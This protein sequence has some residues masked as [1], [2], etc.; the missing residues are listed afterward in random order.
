MRKGKPP[1]VKG[2]PKPSLEELRHELQAEQAAREGS[3]LPTVLT[4]QYEKARQY[5]QD[6][7]IV[8][9]AIE[10]QIGQVAIKYLD[11]REGIALDPTVPP[12]QPS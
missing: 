10:P 2:R 7:E 12:P 8:G 3:Q 5:L 6:P 9:D 4:A 1:K 11:A